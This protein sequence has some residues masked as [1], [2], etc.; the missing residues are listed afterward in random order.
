MSATIDTIAPQGGGEAPAC[1]VPVSRRSIIRRATALSAF[2]FTAIA[3]RSDPARAHAGQGSPYCCD[4][5][6]PDQ[7]CAP[8]SGDPPFWC[9]HGGFKRVWYC[10]HTNGYFYGCGECQ[11]T[12]GTCR[13]GGT[14]YCS[15][16]WL[17]RTFC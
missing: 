12:T 14:Y 8:L 13:N 7:W 3:A 17:V 10:C 16:A 5:A 6:R 11:A 4:L 1:E 15:Y 9:D 2:L